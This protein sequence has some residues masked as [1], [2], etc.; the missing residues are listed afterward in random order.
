MQIGNVPKLLNGTIFNSLERP[1]TPISRS[2]QYL[3]LNIS[4][5]V[6]DMDI[7]SMGD[8]QGLILAL[9]KSVISNDLE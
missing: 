9:L 1:L 2:R 7:V 8:R 4:E 6:R 3:T 5:T